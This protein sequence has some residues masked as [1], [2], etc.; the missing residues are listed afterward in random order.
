MQVGHRVFLKFNK[1]DI[2]LAG[3]LSYTQFRRDGNV[4]NGLFPNDSYG[5]GAMNTFTNYAVKGGVTYKINGRNYLYANGSY[6]TRAPYF[7]NVYI[8][9]RTRNDEQDNI[10]SETIYTA[11]A[12]YIMNAPKLKIR[13]GGYYTHFANGMDVMSFYHD[14]YQNFVNYA[15]SGIDKLHFGGEFGVEYKLTSSLSVNAAAAV[16]RYYYDSRQKA[17][18]TVDNNASVLGEQIIYAKKFP[19]SFHSTRSV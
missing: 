2:F 12:G 7:E 18:I 17:V 13:I 10:K 11:E 9:P 14:T 16:G 5:K 8:S 1:V 15:L 6:L 19:C 4:K 3:Q